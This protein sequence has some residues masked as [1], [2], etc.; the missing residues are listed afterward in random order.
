MAPESHLGADRHKWQPGWRAGDGREPGAPPLH[1]HM[2]LGLVPQHL[3]GTHCVT[4][5]GSGSLE[6]AETLPLGQ[7]LIWAHLTEDATEA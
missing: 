5:Y 4:R 1:C 7:C 6:T 3:L 2:E